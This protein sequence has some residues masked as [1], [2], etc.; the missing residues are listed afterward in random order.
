MNESGSPVR[1]GAGA[2]A[3]LDALVFDQDRTQAQPPRHGH[4]VAVKAA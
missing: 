2:G 1:L 4:P 3:G